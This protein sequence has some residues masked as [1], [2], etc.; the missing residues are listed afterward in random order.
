MQGV[1]RKGASVLVAGL[2]ATT[3]WAGASY[4]KVEAA[5]ASELPDVMLGVFTNS[6]NDSTDTF[7][8]SMDGLHFEK[9][10]EA[11]VNRYPNNPNDGTA[12]GSGTP[13]NPVKTPNGWER[14]W[15]LYSFSCPSIIYHD[16]YFWM[17]AN[18]SN[19]GDDGTLRLVISNSKDLV[20]WCDQRQVK[21]PVPAGYPS[22]GTGSRFDAVAAD[23][24]VGPDG[25]IYVAVSLGRYGAFHGD[26]EN[27]RMAPYMVKVT[28]LAGK[29]D[30]E[31]NPIGNDDSFI[32][33]KTEPAVRINLP[34]ADDDRIDGSWYFEDGRAYLSS[35][36]HGVTHEIWSIGDLGSVGNATAWHKVC[37]DVITGYEA[38]SLTKFKGQ[39]FM[40]TDE[41]ATW[42]PNINERP[43]YYRTGTNVQRSS[44]L[45]GGWTGA[46]LVQAYT[47][48][49][50]NMTVSSPYNDLGDGPR[51]GT[52]I[53]VTDPAAKAVIWNQRAKAGWKGDAPSFWDVSADDWF[54][55][56]VSYAS[57]NGLITGYDSST[58]GPHDTLN[59]AQ[60]A[61][62]LW[63]YFA[64]EEA[65]SYDASTAVNRTGLHGVEDRMWYTGAANWA[66]RTGVINGVGGVDF[67]PYV[68]IDRQ[69]LCTMIGNAAKILCTD[70][71]VGADPSAM[72]RMPDAGS[73]A[74]WATDSVAW[75]INKGVISGVNVNGARMIA[76]NDQVPRCQMAA[77]MMN[78]IQKG[79][80]HR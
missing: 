68:G 80:L 49:G 4:G 65:A 1:L 31:N 56:S 21:V 27:D 72:N 61:V 37:S 73:V 59:R 26:A 71:V 19:G 2:M 14:T 39:Y 43:A 3:L 54:N 55:E 18:E 9:I 76:P 70:S 47:A 78:S 22:N 74:G 11:F 20:H 48:S 33:V 60:A 77:V 36:K 79:T 58:F 8:M 10:S 63:R 30:P 46:N 25:N 35:K 51:H 64:P 16:G 29:N 5:Q 75:A 40:Y 57:S 62:I 32:T 38:P 52:V 66:V 50:Q 12:V 34:E 7:Y 42:T 28:E 23:W 69:M 45:S 17:L 13:A 53:T 41:L 15:P 24:A 67:A 6:Q 44:S